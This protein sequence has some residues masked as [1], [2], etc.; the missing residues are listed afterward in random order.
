MM[1]KKA[2]S[3]IRLRTD[4]QIPGDM[5]YPNETLQTILLTDP[6]PL[7]AKGTG[8]RKQESGDFAVGS[9]RL[10]GR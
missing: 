4:R 5:S 2:D 6:D 8:C 3:E 7:T 10:W 1:R 9:R